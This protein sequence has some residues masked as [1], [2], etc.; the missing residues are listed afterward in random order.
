MDGGELHRGLHSLAGAAG[1][2]A[3]KPLHALAKKLEER[4]EN[5]Q[6]DGIEGGIDELD[7]L[8]EQFIAE[9]AGW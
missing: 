1:M 6:L 7:L 9:S 3:A 4:V 8:V 2:M 5:G